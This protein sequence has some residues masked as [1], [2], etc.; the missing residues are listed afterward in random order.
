MVLADTLAC[1]T[2]H[3][4]PRRTGVAGQGDSGI[5]AVA[6]AVVTGRARVL[7]FDT[8]SGSLVTNIDTGVRSVELLADRDQILLIRHDEEPPRLRLQRWTSQ[9]GVSELSETPDSD[10][11]VLLVDGRAVDVTDLLEHVPGSDGPALTSLF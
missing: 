9:S 5:E 8:A 2:L 10:R 4:R 11:R 7:L 3:L 1:L 6:V